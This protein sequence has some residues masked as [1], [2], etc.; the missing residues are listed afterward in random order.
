MLDQSPGSSL[1]VSSVAADVKGE[2]GVFGSSGAGT[3]TK[4]FDV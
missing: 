3:F 1:G 2:T 4:K